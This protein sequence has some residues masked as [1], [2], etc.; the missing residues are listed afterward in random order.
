MNAYILI[1]F[2]V[3]L[4]AGDFVL[5]NLYRTKMGTEITTGLVFNIFSGLFTA[6]IFF[7]YQWL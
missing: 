6:V 2:A 4:L 3:I 5:Q 1:T 7:F